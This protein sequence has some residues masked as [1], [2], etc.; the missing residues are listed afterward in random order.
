MTAPMR[1]PVRF[2]I[3][4]EPEGLARVRVACT[5]CGGVAEARAQKCEIVQSARGAPG[6]EALAE[7][8]TDMLRPDRCFHALPDELA[9]RQRAAELSHALVEALELRPARPRFWDALAAVLDVPADALRTTLVTPSAVQLP[10]A[11]DAQAAAWPFDAPAVT[12]PA[13]AWQLLATR[14]LI[15]LAWIE[16]PR[17][18]FDVIVEHAGWWSWE[19]TALP[20]PPSVLA[21]VLLAADVPGVLTTE[22][23]ARELAG[24]DAVRWRVLPHA[25]ARQRVHRPTHDEPDAL[26]AQADAHT[27]LTRLSS[28]LP[29]GRVFDLIA[30]GYAIDTVKRRDGASPDVA[31]ICPEP[32]G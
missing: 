31:L 14:G 18:G 11:R 26:R 7:L 8:I 9:R 13:E 4:F 12:E 28:R 17:R 29:Y 20:H 32:V 21:C 1:T 25:R 19:P 23:I 5:A 3:A 2:T 15:P 10:H 24:A 16:D 30:T 27:S 22:A 6:V